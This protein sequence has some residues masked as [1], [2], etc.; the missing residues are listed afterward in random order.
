MIIHLGLFALSLVILVKGT[1]YFVESSARIARKLGVSHMIIGLTLA[2]VGTSLPE[3]ASSVSA[4]LQNYPSII[5]GN[6]IGSNIANIGLVL[7]VSAYLYS[8]KPNHKIYMRDGYIFI[9]S[10]LLLY[11]F[12]S[13]NTIVWWEATFLLI[14]YFSYLIFL[15]RTREKNNRKYQFHHFLD[16]FFKLDYITVFRKKTIKKIVGGKKAKSLQ[17]KKSISLARAGV[18]MDVIT[19][20][21]SGTTVVIAAKYLIQEAVWFA[22][23]LNVPRTL[24]GLSVIAIGTSL[25]ELTV[26]ITAAR[27]GFGDLVLGNILGSNIANI[28]LIGGVSSL[29][30]PLTISSMTLTY[31]L[32]LLGFFSLFFI[33]LLSSV[34]KI[35]RRHGIFLLVFYVL[36]L[37]YVFVQGVI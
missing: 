18:F 31:T 26:S 20:L 15:I 1:D 6:I 27:K 11:F 4:A 9:L 14:L 30:T 5:T 29:I 2:A 37:A 33:Y 36:F 19:L 25:P 35:T 16:Y 7:G 12:S 32:P 28:F 13:D 23:F 21:F 10:I 3:L 24:V 8:F 22:D 17:E 34:K